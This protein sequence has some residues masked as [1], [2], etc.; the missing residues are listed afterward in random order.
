MAVESTKEKVGKLLTNCTAS[1]IFSSASKS[2]LLSL[3]Y[4]S[5]CAS[6]LVLASAAITFLPFWRRKGETWNHI[7]HC[8]LFHGSCAGIDHPTI[9]GCPLW[10]QSEL[11]LTSHVPALERP[12]AL[13]GHL[14]GCSL[15][16]D[17]G[18][19]LIRSSTGERS[20][21]KLPWL[22]LAFT[23]LQAFRTQASVC[24]WSHW[25]FSLCSLPHGPLHRQLT[26]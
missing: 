22:L 25:Q 24:S 6:G 1:D 3:S 23:S 7:L 20:T 18:W 2:W 8:P 10:V 16:A 13:L 9:W 21:S 17:Q 4:L 14:R 11:P 19:G 15:S 12:T 26:T 5:L